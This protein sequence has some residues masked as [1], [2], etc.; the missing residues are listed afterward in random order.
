LNRKGVL[1]PSGQFVWVNRKVHSCSL[2]GFRK[3]G[4]FL[5]PLCFWSNSETLRTR[6]L[7]TEG[8]DKI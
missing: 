8:K 4:V 2:S 3:D 5:L 1:Y 7:W 6:Q